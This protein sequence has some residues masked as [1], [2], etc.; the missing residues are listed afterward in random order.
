[1]IL[2]SDG[3]APLTTLKEVHRTLE[4]PVE[5]LQSV[6]REAFSTGG[7]PDFFFLP[8][9]PGQD[10]KGFI[11]LLRDVSSISMDHIVRSE[12]HAKLANK[13]DAPHRVG[14]LSDRLRFAISQKLAFLFSR[15]GL[16]T[17]F[18]SACEETA[19]ILAAEIGFLGS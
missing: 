4:K 7:F 16:D 3:T 13:L 10:S 5:V 6:V 2:T 9:L 18:E 19:E 17:T 12:R 11:V 15:I 1:M 8:E 14:R